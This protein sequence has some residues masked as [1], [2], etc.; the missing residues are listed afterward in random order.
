VRLQ[1]QP[2]A[3]IPVLFA[4]NRHA[5]GKDDPLDFYDNK[6]AENSGFQR[7]Q[8][9]IKVPPRHVRGKVERPSWVL[10]TLQKAS[11]TD[12][13]RAFNAPQVTAED[14]TKDFSYVDKIKPL[15][16]SD[17]DAELANAI[18]KSKSKTAILYVHG[19]ANSF[20]DAVFRTAQIVHDLETPNYDVVP[21][22]FSW[23]SDPGLSKMDYK[24]A[25][26]AERL[27]RSST[28]LKNFL[29]EIKDN[30]DIGTVHIIAHSMGAEVLG[31]AMQK[32]G[33]EMGLM[34][35]KKSTLVKPVFRQ[36]VFAAPDVTVKTF[37]EVIEPAIKSNHSITTYGAKTDIALWLSSIINGEDRA[38]RLPIKLAKEWALKDCV[39][40]IDVTSVTK[41]GDFLEHS[42]WA[43]SKH[44]LNDLRFVL[45]DGLKPSS[46]GLT[47]Q[48]NSKWSWSL[49][50]SNNQQNIEPVARASSN[51]PPVLGCSRKSVQ[52]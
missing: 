35:S 46:R 26:D 19:Y 48:D 28:D 44:V 7:G 17:F 49:L 23:P 13:A 34:F 47:P 37:N 8:A 12:L 42:T 25:R 52:K 3:Q 21:L 39:D 27:D 6:L 50:E 43:E 1:W 16:A 38:G 5:T 18:K 24:K 30:T 9:L 41:E 33:D 20:N 32:M 14:L 36:I 31:Q 11:N 40:T 45:R 51:N 15:G 2:E 29:K 22:M 4:T 10:V